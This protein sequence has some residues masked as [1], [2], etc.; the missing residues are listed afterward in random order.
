MFLVGFLV[1]LALVMVYQFAGVV[2]LVGLAVGWLGGMVTYSTMEQANVLGNFRH[3]PTDHPASGAGK[4]ASAKRQGHPSTAGSGHDTPPSPGAGQRDH[5]PDGGDRKP[6][7]GVDVAT[8]EQ[9][10]GSGNG[11]D[12]HVTG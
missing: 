10:V 3:K 12:H 4:T 11:L 8:G 6:D 7:R 9:P 5:Q 2:V 1:A